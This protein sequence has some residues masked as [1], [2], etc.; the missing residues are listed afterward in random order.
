MVFFRVSDHIE[1]VAAIVY[2][3]QKHISEL[4]PDVVVSGIVVELIDE[5]VVIERREA[6]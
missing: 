5:T 2:V 6:L 4:H 3:T 1:S